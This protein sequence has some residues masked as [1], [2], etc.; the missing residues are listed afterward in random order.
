VSR[1]TLRA[2]S[3][4]RPDPV[5]TAP[6]AAARPSDRPPPDTLAT[7][8]D[9]VEEWLD[10]HFFRPVGA[11][12]TRALY[13]TRVTPDQV[14]LISLVIGLV[15]GH[16]FL[17]TGRWLNALGFVLFIVS[18]LFDS[19]DGQLARL[20]GTST[21]FGR[22]LDGS[23]DALRFVNLGVHLIIRL[24]IHSGWSWI[25]AAVMVGIA[26][27]SHSTQSA[28]V[29][30]V[31]HAY[32]ALGNGKG[33]ELDVDEVAIPADAT[34]IQRITTAIY[35]AYAKRQAQM[36]PQTVALV[37]AAGDPRLRPAAMSAYRARVAPLLAWCAWLGQNIRF[38]VLGVTAVAGWPAGLLWVTILPMNAVLIGLVAAQERRAGALLR[39][40]SLASSPAPPTSPAVPIGSD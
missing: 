33:S 34:W 27:L 12:I 25:A 9:E 36:F 18:D 40:G 21:R 32:L 35:R 29:D 17:Y 15:A 22:A 7:K 28:A 30:F 4:T 31:R 10:L 19:A 20:R 14:T 11:R 24:A 2:T 6:D 39:S 16:M 8:G 38:I 26:T 3:D 37:R 13:P 5:H 23:S 1:E